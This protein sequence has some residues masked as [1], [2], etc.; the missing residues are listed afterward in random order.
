MT[1]L[2]E[3]RKG[4]FSQNPVF[5][6]MLGLCPV[7]A[8][9]TSVNNAVGMGTAVIF[10]LFCSNTI[11]SLIRNWVPPKIRIPIYISII[12]TFVTI[13]DLTMA[14]YFPELHK[15]LGLFIPLIVVNCIILGRAEAFAGK[16]SVFLSIIDAFG[17]GI[18]FTV[19][20]VIIATFREILGNGTWFGMPVFGSQFEPV[21]I[22]I[23]SPGAFLTI[24]LL[25]GFFNWFE[26]YRKIHHL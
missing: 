7:L 10:V 22:M 21:L 17:M 6:L 14:G 24:G 9:S 11:V 3:F 20:L 18:G 15:S 5:R 19:S 26:H 1:V 16:H 8:T 13:V 4:I 25:I 2:K 12:A 23:L